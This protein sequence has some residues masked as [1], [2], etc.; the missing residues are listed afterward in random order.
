MM[1]TKRIPVQAGTVTRPVRFQADNA[2]AGMAL[3]KATARKSRPVK[4]ERITIRRSSMKPNPKGRGKLL[5]I[6]N[7]SANHTRISL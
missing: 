5:G 6:R 2:V 1:R 7:E 3:I 4:T